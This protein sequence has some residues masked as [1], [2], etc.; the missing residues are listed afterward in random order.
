MAQE[1][2]FKK[3]VKKKMDLKKLLKMQHRETRRGNI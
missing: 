2:Q 1:A 3:K